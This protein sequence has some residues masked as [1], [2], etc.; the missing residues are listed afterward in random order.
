MCFLPAQVVGFKNRDV[1]FDQ[2]DG[3]STKWS[4]QL[5]QLKSIF[6]KNMINVK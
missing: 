1:F 3:K 6:Y 2:L 4:K 5:V